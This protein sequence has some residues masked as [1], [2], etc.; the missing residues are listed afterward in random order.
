MFCGIVT[1]ARVV[2]SQSP[3]PVPGF[4]DFGHGLF[5]HP[6]AGARVGSR[7]RRDGCRGW[8]GGSRDL[9]TYGG[10]SI[11]GYLDTPI[12]PV[13]VTVNARG[14]VTAVTFTDGG[15]G[16]TASAAASAVRQLEEYFTNRRRAF[17][18][19]LEPEGTDFERKVWEELLKIPFGA[20]DTYG[21]IAD[22]LG[23]LAASR[24]VGV[25][26]ARNPI[27]IVIPCH[28]VIGSDGNLTGYAGG[29]H[30]KKWLLSH[31]SGQRLLDH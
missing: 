13:K 26:N 6:R 5:H 16:E 27:A 3:F 8:Y 31:E 25:A 10:L 4:R 19:D 20:T 22:R 14:A 21:A 1:S 28:R 2:A 29:L 9:S 15:V 30:R 18:L 23:N 24:A 12:G 11:N 17:E 7:L